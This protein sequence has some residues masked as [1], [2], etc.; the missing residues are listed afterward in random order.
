M[1][2]KIFLNLLTKAAWLETKQK[3]GKVEAKIKKTKNRVKSHSK[4]HYTTTT[5]IDVHLA[6]LL[7]KQKRLQAKMTH[8]YKRV[9]R[10][11]HE[12]CQTHTYLATGHSR[13]LVTI[14]V[15]VKIPNDAKF[16]V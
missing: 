8:I 1:K 6:K 5:K 7:K 13:A 10:L 11:A 12:R 14:A 3:V 16:I 2:N 9:L 15:L 4:H